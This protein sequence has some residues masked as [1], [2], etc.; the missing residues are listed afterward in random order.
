VRQI[1]ML[2]AMWRGLETDYGGVYT[3]T[4]GETPDTVANFRV[5]ARGVGSTFRRVSTP[6]S[7]Q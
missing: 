2:R 3:G 6:F 1:R 4:Q 7:D 5:G